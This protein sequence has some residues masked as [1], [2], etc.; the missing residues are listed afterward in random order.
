MRVAKKPTFPAFWLWG[1]PPHAGSWPTGLQVN[2]YEGRDYKYNTS[3][4]FGVGYDDEADK[5][6]PHRGEFVWVKT[7][8]YADL[9]DD[10][11]VY[12]GVWTPTEISFFLDDTKIVTFNDST[13]MRQYNRCPTA[14]IVSL[15]MWPWYTEGSHLDVDYIRVYKPKNNSNEYPSVEYDARAKP[16][17]FFE[18]V[19]RLFTPTMPFTAMKELP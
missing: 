12:T 6:V 17:S 1:E 14:L 11:H 19:R 4:V 7:E 3:R 16:V 15:Q 8:G 9:A 18:R 5:F 10:F 2:I 13:I